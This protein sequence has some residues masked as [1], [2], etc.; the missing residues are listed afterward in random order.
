MGL[1][2]ELVLRENLPLVLKEV[3]GREPQVSELHSFNTFML[4][5]GESGRS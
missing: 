5:D 2:E 1:T 3:L 4:M